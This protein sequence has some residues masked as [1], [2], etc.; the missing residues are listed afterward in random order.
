MCDA[1]WPQ[2][3]FALEYNGRAEHEGDVSEA[4]DRE[5]AGRLQAIGVRMETVTAF[6]LARATAFDKIAR[7]AA[8]ATRCRRACRRVYGRSCFRM[9]TRA[10]RHPAS[11]GRPCTSKL[12]DACK[13]PS[14]E[15]LQRKERR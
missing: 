1:F 12:A 6:E 3:R 13:T 8:V 2:A 4:H 14:S 11:R 5:R 9:W 10:C 7:R 15:S